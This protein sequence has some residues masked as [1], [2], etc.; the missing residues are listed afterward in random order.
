LVFLGCGSSFK[1]SSSTAREITVAAASNLTGVFDEIA[2]AFT[3]D[4]GIKVTL[5]FASTAQLTQ[6]IENHAPFDVFAAADVEHI[7]ELE[8]KGKLLPGTRSVYA[9]GLLALWIPKADTTRINKLEDLIHP[10]IRFIA[11]AKPSAAPYGKAA[12]EAL[13]KSGVWPALAPKIVYAGNISMAK[14]FAATGNADAA[15]TAYSLL[16]NAAGQVVRVDENLYQPI[17]QALAIVASSQK[18]DLARR[19]TAYVLGDRGQDKLQRYGYRIA[20]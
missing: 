20:R 3:N 7:D 13:Q 10:S 18:T 15:F 9:R 2:K 8:R 14:Q 16:L 11:I 19:F 1:D 6:Q 17:N 12:V 4:T 5:S